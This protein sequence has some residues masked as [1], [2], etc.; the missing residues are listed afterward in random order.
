MKIVWEGTWERGHLRSA[1]PFL[2][3][4]LPF[5][6]PFYEGVGEG[7][8]LTRL[9]LW[10]Y[11]LIAGFTNI[12]WHRTLSR[13]EVEAREPG[14]LREKLRGGA[15]Y[16]DCRTDD[17]RLVLLN[18]KLAHGAGARIVPYAR[19]EELRWK[20]SRVVGVRFRDL[21]QGGVH[22]AAAQLV[23]N[24]TGA[25]SDGFRSQVPGA[26]ARL[27]PTKGVHILVR[28]ERLGNRQAVVMR[29]PADERVVFA[30]PWGPFALV[31][32]TDT[33]FR[34]NPD[35]VRAEVEDVGYL[36]D[37][38]N[39]TFPEAQVGSEDVVSSYAALRPLVAEYGVS[40]SDVSRDFRIVEDAPGLLSVLGGKLT[41][42][43]RAARQALAQVVR[44]LPRRRRGAPSP[45][46]LCMTSAQL[47]NLR[48]WLEEEGE[49]LGWGEEDVEHILA[50]YGGESRE[51]VRYAQGEELRRRV[52]PSLPYV[53]AEIAYAVDH[54]M[55]LHLEDVLVRRTGVMYEDP[56]HGLEV[57]RE[58]A[59]FVGARLGWD[60]ER[61]RREEEA[62][63]RAVM[64]SQAFRE[65]G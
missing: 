10:L 26:A 41:T 14:L 60:E 50:A 11:D 39:H 5:L 65:G 30:L 27:R 64:T 13:Q 46:P 33:D 8:L 20:G 34:G 18:A 57:A 47:E 28:R 15:L 44:R 62:Y 32:T 4:P 17:F 63:A 37:A 21:L 3:R 19:A 49:R 25:W 22:E 29:S 45:S 40:E 1:Y 7:P 2:V 55:A 6:I 61:R 59:S 48:R 16:Y 31:G 12:R 54:E 24:A 53:W 56:D 36:L 58:V 38:L 35:D 43:R 9:G 51:V 23:V 52:V 42:Y